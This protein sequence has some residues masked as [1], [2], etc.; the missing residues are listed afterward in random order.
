[1]FR[2]VWYVR[3]VAKV[4]RE[5]VSIFVFVVVVERVSTNDNIADLPSRQEFDLLRAQGA[6]EL[7]PKL[8]DVFN[9]NETWSMLQEAWNCESIRQ[10]TLPAIVI[11]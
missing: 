11:D 8:D 1:M 7:R 4:W 6:V 5:P 9:E 2:F 3:Q 10:P